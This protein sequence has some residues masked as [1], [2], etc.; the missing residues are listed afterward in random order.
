MEGIE[1]LKLNRSAKQTYFCIDSRRACMYALILE[2][3]L[4]KAISN[5]AVE[6]S[7]FQ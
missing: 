4:C 7:Y 3:M 5:G 1:H 2:D 6:Q